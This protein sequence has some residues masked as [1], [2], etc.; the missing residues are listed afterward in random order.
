MSG[1]QTQIY[2]YKQLVYRSSVKPDEKSQAN[3][4]FHKKYLSRLK[5]IFLITYIGIIP[6][7]ETPQ[8][9]IDKLKEEGLTR[10]HIFLDCEGKGVPFSGNPCIAPPAVAF[11]EFSCLAFFIYFRWFKTKWGLVQ[12]KHR[13][14]NI[15]LAVVAVIIFS[16]NIL[17]MIFF[18]KPWISQMIRPLVYLSFMHL[19]RLNTRHFYHDIKD[20]AVILIA[21]F[22][23]VLCYSIVGH[24]LF[25]YSY[26]GFISFQSLPDAFFN[27]LILL[28]TA[29]F[30]D[31]MLPS[32]AKHYWSMLF[33]VS[34]LILGLYFMLSFLLANVFNKFKDRLGG[35]AY[36][37]N[38][39]TEELL[40]DL[41]DKYDDGKKGY[42][43]KDEGKEFFTILLNLK[44]GSR[45]H[46]SAAQSLI[47]LM[48]I[49]DLDY[50]EK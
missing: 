39:K 40:S 9:C 50:I 20:S 24:F 34:F 36:K 44:L 12:K 11:L 6:F 1:Y 43:D 31:I 27:M 16:E 46:V 29:N 47:E 13:Q 18:F 49:T 23:F 14:S 37:I 30:P 45:R 17:A 8:W 38:A 21:I 25:R 33:F 41:F 22:L 42:L 32:Y 7:L 35:Q 28:T 26:V 15:V 3:Y 19:V 2:F 10:G 5:I 4:R 48:D